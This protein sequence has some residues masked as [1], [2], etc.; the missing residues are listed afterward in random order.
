MLI[1]GCGSS[2]PEGSAS[3]S[4]SSTGGSGS[5]GGA[6]NSDSD[7]TPGSNS[8]SDS[9]PTTTQGS[10]SEGQTEATTAGTTGTAS[11]A[12]ITDTFERWGPDLGIEVVYKNDSL[13]LGFPNGVGPE[14]T[15]MKAAGVV[16]PEVQG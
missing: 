9:T 10:M 2:P 13:A 7:P 5:S 15:A 12:S 1:S 3:A 4:A 14:V 6:S 8:N 11:V 16:L